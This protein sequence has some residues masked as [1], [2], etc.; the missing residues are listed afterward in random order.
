MKKI[1]IVQSN[2]IPWKGYFDLIASV[3]ELILYDDMQ[4]TRRDWR[5]RNKIKTAQGLQWLTI[6]IISKGRY[7]QKIREV[8][9]D[10]DDWMELQWRTITQNYRRSPN[11]LEI[12]SILEPLYLE[13]KYA[14][15]SDL[16][17]TFIEFICS[18]LGIK[19]IIKNSWD[20]SL[21][22][23]KTDRLVDLCLQA[24]GTEYLSGPSAKNYL[25]EKLFTAKGIKLSWIDYNE[26]PEY[27]QLWGEF[28]H[29]VSIIDLL[30]SCGK[31]A[32]T[33]LKYVIK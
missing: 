16:N 25:D 32:S 20:Y 6:P 21:K 31:D 19:T 27:R 1:A 33:Y 13:K 14:K 9:I 8:E 10:G 18:Y 26:Y 2:Y 11:Y 30:F 23:G 28:I 15:L 17:R 3:D 5:N 7:L 12:A 22:E 29:E 4:Y 24:G